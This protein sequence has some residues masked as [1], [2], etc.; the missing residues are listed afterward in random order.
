MENQAPPTI[1]Y[2]SYTEAQKKA[3]Y[4]YREKNKEKLKEAGR[5]YAKNWYDKNQDKHNKNCLERY[6]KNK[7]KDLV[8][9]NEPNEN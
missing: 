8:S 1:I 9:K 4:K 3:I 6:H 2:K 7:K 5:I